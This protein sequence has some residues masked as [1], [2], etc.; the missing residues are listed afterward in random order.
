[1]GMNISDKK[2]TTLYNRIDV[3]IRLACLSPVAS[4][5]MVGEGFKQLQLNNHLKRTWNHQRSE[6]NGNEIEFDIHPQ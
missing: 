6:D 3:L 1:M 5:R 4:I 2:L